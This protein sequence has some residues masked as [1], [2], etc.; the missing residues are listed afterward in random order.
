MGLV[1]LLLG[2]PSETFRVRFE[3]L[4]QARMARFFPIRSSYALALA[5]NGRKFGNS[6]LQFRDN[7]PIGIRSAGKALIGRTKNLLDSV[8]ATGCSINQCQSRK[9]YP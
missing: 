6:F 7:S 8:A 2:L 4:R 1:T 5:L 9:L 3:A